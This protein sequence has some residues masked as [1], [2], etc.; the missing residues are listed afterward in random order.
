MLSGTCNIWIL[1]CYGGVGSILVMFD[2]LN[3]YILYMCL[4]LH[5]LE[6]PWPG[7]LQNRIFL[8]NHVV[9]RPRGSYEPR[10]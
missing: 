4:L 7:C 9:R 5:V 10:D 3:C 6:G 8:K 1:M 2:V